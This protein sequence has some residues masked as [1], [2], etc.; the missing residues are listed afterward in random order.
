MGDSLEDRG[1]PEDWY[2][3]YVDAD[4][5]EFDYAYYRC[6]CGWESECV[7]HPSMTEWH[8]DGHRQFGQT[9][10]CGV[11][12]HILVFKDGTVAEV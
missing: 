4:D 10:D 1:P 3:H 12:R 9:V 6:R 7:S 2:P 11:G 8:A 5:V